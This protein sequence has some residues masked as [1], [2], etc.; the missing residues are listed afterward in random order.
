MNDLI[1]R[2]LAMT[3]DFFCQNHINNQL[4]NQ[5]TI[6][7]RSARESSTPTTTEAGKTRKQCKNTT[8]HGTCNNKTTTVASI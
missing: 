4:N 3:S 2:D 5:K 6:V 7:A 1:F 8:K